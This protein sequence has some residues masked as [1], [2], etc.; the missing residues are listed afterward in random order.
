[1]PLKIV[2][3]GRTKR[4]EMTVIGQPSKKLANKILKVVIQFSK[5]RAT[6]KDRLIFEFFAKPSAVFNAIKRCHNK[7]CCSFLRC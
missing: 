1:M 7:G 4:I 3:R 2:K 5:L 6:Q